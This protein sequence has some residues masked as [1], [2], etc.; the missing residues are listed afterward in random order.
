MTCSR[1]RWTVGRHE[2]APAP[3]RV[4]RAVG[5]PRLVYPTRQR[6]FAVPAVGPTVGDRR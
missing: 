5:T 4:T 3:G 6:A 2:A 1:D